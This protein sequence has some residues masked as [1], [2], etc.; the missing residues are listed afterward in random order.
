MREL[1]HAPHMVPS[2]SDHATPTATGRGIELW[3][4][5]HW[6]APR[7]H[8]TESELRIRCLTAGRARA[9]PSAGPR[10]PRRDGDS[11]L[12]HTGA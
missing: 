9:H 3:T 6:T 11:A 7:T 12:V 2:A 1:V 10:A 4:R 8:R 5:A